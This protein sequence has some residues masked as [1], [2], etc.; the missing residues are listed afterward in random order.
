MLYLY[1][2][3][4]CVAHVPVC[5]LYLQDTPWLDPLTHNFKTRKLFTEF[6]ADVSQSVSHRQ[7]ARTCTNCTFC[8]E[9]HTFDFICAGLQ[10]CRATAVQMKASVGAAKVC[11]D[12]SEGRTVPSIC[13]VTD[14][15]WG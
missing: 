9:N 12:V 14:T 5:H 2:T 3:C 13:S 4:T 11:S 1:G 8:R 15:V 10:D 7:T 6:Y